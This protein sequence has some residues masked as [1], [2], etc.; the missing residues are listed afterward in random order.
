MKI[1]TLRF[2]LRLAVVGAP[3]S[4]TFVTSTAGSPFQPS[5]AINYTFD[6]NGNRERMDDPSGTTTHQIDVLDRVTG[7]INSVSLEWNWGF[8]AAG[9]QISQSNPNGTS[10]GLAF[11]E[12]D[13]GQNHPGKGEQL[14]QIQHLTGANVLAQFDYTLNAVGNRTRI[15]RSG[16]VLPSAVMKDYV[17]DGLDRLTGVVSTDVTENEAFSFDAVGNQLQNG[18]AHDAGNRLTEDANGNLTRKTSKADPNDVTRYTWD[19]EN[20]LIRVERLMAG[21]LQLVADYKYD[22]FGRRIQKAVQDFSAGAPVPGALALTRC[23]YDGGG[24]LLAA[25]TRAHSSAAE[26]G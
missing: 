4:A 21:S 1:H 12:A 11:D 8:D 24:I 17:Y 7:L 20:H 5:V 19:A 13:C 15:T 2:I 3:L 6:K 23:S 26:S 10:V 14:K 22:A 18:Q 9:R 25:S 16:Q